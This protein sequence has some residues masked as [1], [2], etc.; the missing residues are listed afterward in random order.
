MTRIRDIRLIPLAYRMPRVRA[1]GMAR[2]L[3]AERGCSLVE[4]ET[5]DGV[6]GIGEAWGPAKA[7]AGYLEVIKPAYIGRELFER[8]L[9]WSDLICRRYHLGLQNQMTACASGINIAIYDALGKTLGL[10]VCKLLGGLGRDRIP[11]YASDGYLTGDPDNQLPAQL[12][13]IADKGFPGAKFKIGI[14]PKSD[15]ERVRLARDIL[16]EEMLLLVDVNGNY[17]VDL[18]LESMR[19]TMPYDVHLYEEPLPPQDFRGYEVLSARAPLPVAT[20]EALYTV[21][22]FARLIE[23]RAVD[24]V[25]PD[26]TLCGGLDQA[27]AIA[28]LCQLHNIR[29]SPHVWGSAV[30]LA[31]AVHFMAAL[32]GYPHTDHIPAPTLIEYDVGDNPLRDELLTRPLKPVNG[33]IA[34]PEAPGLGIELDPA[35]IKR[36]R[37][38]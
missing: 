20:G 18:T 10:P 26:L 14:S 6:V 25:Q 34:V 1:Y 37:V 33:R 30:G 36:F 15:E 2:S 19:R 32:P 35:A 8:E 21:W 27:R 16:G 24:I 4:V 23:A 9:I 12:E 31:A 22:D 3:T 5:E 17:T 28:M 11:V 7:T 38:E 29:F 13:R